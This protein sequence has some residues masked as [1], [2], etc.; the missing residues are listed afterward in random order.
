MSDLKQK[1]LDILF[2]DED[3]ET[4]VKDTPVIKKEAVK[5]EEKKEE[6]EESAIKA[7]D[8]L[9]RKA[10]KSPFINLDNTTK[11][12]HFDLNDSNQYEM[13]SQISPIF[14]LIANE[15][16][17]KV[18]VSSEITES[19]ITKPA[20]SH[21]DIITSPIYGYGSKEDAMDN[22]YDVKG[23]S[24]NDEDMRSLFDSADEPFDTL[25]SSSDDNDVNLFELFGEDK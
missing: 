3:D 4:E 1:F 2:E 7:K 8:I 23:L 25:S 24:A 11:G 13:S 6:I 22:N 5:K 10:G 18:N 17:R 9:Y 19:Q 12:T 15:D 16:K 14:G 21:L 20:D